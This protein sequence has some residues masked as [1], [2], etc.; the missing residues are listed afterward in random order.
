MSE[1]REPTAPAIA[2]GLGGLDS[3]LCLAD[4]TDGECV[5][6][7]QDAL[8]GSIE[9]RLA[10]EMRRLVSAL[11]EFGSRSQLIGEEIPSDAKFCKSVT[12]AFSLCSLQLAYALSQSM[13]RLVFADDGAE[14]LRQ[15][16]LGLDDLFRALRNNVLK[17]RP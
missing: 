8:L 3:S 12:V 5:V 6:Q 1:P 17:G 14:Y 2:D 11:G 9:A 7:G 15:L 16:G 10:E 4:R 13:K